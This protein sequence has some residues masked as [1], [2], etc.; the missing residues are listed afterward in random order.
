MKTEYIGQYSEARYRLRGNRYSWHHNDHTRDSDRLVMF[1][2]ESHAREESTANFK[3][4]QDLGWRHG[5]E[6][7]VVND[8]KIQYVSERSLDGSIRY[9]IENS[10]WYRDL[11]DTEEGWR[12]P[13]VET[14]ITDRGEC[15]T[16]R[17][18]RHNWLISEHM[19]VYDL[20]TEKR[21]K[22]R[23][24]IIRMFWDYGFATW[25]GRPPTVARIRWSGSRE[26][27]EELSDLY[28]RHRWR[29][30][31]SDMAKKITSAYRSINRYAAWPGSW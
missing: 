6:L 28:E 8:S 10:Q 1:T 7:M 5:A 11:A 12:K 14:D 2:V 9:E 25:R 27:L 19:G 29:S 20:E 17:F 21:V 30:Y 3:Y 31:V 24:Q 13:M 26:E 18:H 23:E 15:V 4:L 16:V 22:N